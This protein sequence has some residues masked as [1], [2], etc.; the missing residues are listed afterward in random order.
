MLFVG[1]IVQGYVCKSIPHM[2]SYLVWVYNTETFATLPKHHALKEYRIGENL[3]AAVMDVRG[4]RITLSQRIPQFTK[5]MFEYHFRDLLRENEWIVKR[6]VVQPPMG[7]IL[8][9]AFDARWDFK[10]MNRAFVQKKRSV[11]L[12]EN[13][14]LY[15]IPHRD[16]PL[17]LVAEALQPAPKERIL[18]IQSFAPG[19][20]TVVVPDELVGGFAG[21]RG[22]NLKLSARLIGYQI[23][24]IGESHFLNPDLKRKEEMAWNK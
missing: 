1:D 21:T 18:T 14:T 15:L 5:K 20:A 19:Q 17:E 10:N 24:I 11:P 6:A 3:M 7:K 8:V 9:K 13:V 12:W 22:I 2:E 4:A 23:E 16:D